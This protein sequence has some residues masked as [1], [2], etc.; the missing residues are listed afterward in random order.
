MLRAMRR[1]SKSWVMKAILGLLA[2]TFVAFFGGVG[3]FGGFGSGGHGGGHAGNVGNLNTL[4]QVGDIDIDSR[5]VTDAYNQQLST[6]AQLL[7]GRIDPEQ[8]RQLGLL[9]QT[10]QRLVSQALIDQTAADL[11]V[12]ISDQAVAQ[13]VRTLPQFQGT[14][15][16]FDPNLFQATLRQNG[17]G[18][19]EF[20]DSIRSNLARGQV[21]GTVQDAAT[22]PF[23]LV[24]AIYNYR[25]ER[26]VVESVRIGAIDLPN[27]SEPTDAEISAFYEEAKNRFL[28]P[29]YRQISVA[30]LSL[31]QLAEQL[32]VD[33]TELRIDFEIRENEFQTPEV[34]EVSQALFTDQ[35]AAQRAKAMIAGGQDFAAAAEDVSGSAPL[36]LGQLAHRDLLPELADATFALDT[37]GISDPLE[38]PFGWHLMQVSEIIPEDIPVFEEV[39]DQLAADRALIMAR[40]QIFEVMDAVT[41]TYA[42]GAGLE[43]AVQE[44]GLQLQAISAV[45]ANGTD[46]QGGPVAG[47]DPDG[48]M[49]RTAF[50]TPV[51]EDSDVVETP[52]G[53][54]FVLRVTGVT[55]PAPHP[56][57]KVREDVVAAWRTQQITEGAQDLANQLVDRVAGGKALADAAAELDLIVELSEPVLR[58]GEGGELPPTLVGLMFESKVDD[59][60]VSPDGES[61][62]VGRLAEILPASGATALV[63]LRNEL[64][65]DVGLDIQA[66]LTAA[67]QE[68]YDVDIDRAALDGLFQ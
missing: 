2:L 6:F 42:G 57:A 20:V 10:I 46:T 48:L 18:E 63:S 22:A 5:T 40:D 34:R 7:G 45:A 38:S 19:G 39:R 64:T 17:I 37:Q 49:L 44:N 16:A 51:G 32:T 25:Q 1:G 36:D 35:D 62:V 4:V 26:R 28:A 14:D 29:E 15:G 13:T 61:V 52:D 33:D 3:G 59:I 8:A 27:L 67:L 24:D 50:S 65:R 11:G 53:G 41:D 30:S 9:D 23:A 58:T 55:E 66:Q 31:A 54:F 56:L 21:L 43:D 60:S 47:L 12:T 68:R